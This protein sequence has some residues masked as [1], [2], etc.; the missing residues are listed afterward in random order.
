[1]KNLTSKQLRTI[2][3]SVKRLFG[4]SSFTSP[5][6]DKNQSPKEFLT[7]QLNLPDHRT[8]SLTDSGLE[9]MRKI[10]ATLDEANIFDGKVNYAD[11]WLACRQII[12]NF[13][14]RLEMPENSAE[15]VD[16]I[17]KNLS[18]KIKVFTFVVPLFGVEM[19]GIDEIPL[20]T[21]RVIKPS[22]DFFDSF[23][24]KHDHVDTK[25][26]F[27][28]SNYCL[29]LIGS[30]DGTL[31]VA[32]EKF[33]INAELSVG[34]LSVCAASMY[35]H[36]ASGF[37]IGTIMS[38]EQAYGRAIWISWDN[39][40]MAATMHYKFVSTQNFPVDT[41]LIQQLATSDV[42]KKAFS[43]IESSQRTPL[44]DAIARS[45]Y[46]FS[47]AQREK[48]QAMKL[49]KFWSCVEVFFSAENQDITRS[50]SVGLACVLV[51]G[52]YKFVAEQDYETLKKRIANLYK[53]RSRAVHRA[54]HQHVSYTDTA[55][56][57]KL[58]AQMILNMISFAE[59]GRKDVKEIKKATDQI[60]K[61]I[62]VDQQR[63]ELR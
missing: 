58:V 14:S 21:M 9:H 7:R 29:W 13:L 46:W 37:R 33:R 25:T 12:E 3:F 26:L 40:S 38:P 32:L 27:E 57:S 18:A 48:F 28:T 45:I 30:A 20:G 8:I 15:F 52:G 5:C 42:L 31:D 51:F 2:E 16:L 49:V 59:Q 4:D 23:G 55:D 17:R 22:M 24:I 10:V 63:S 19:D 54:S 41:H 34:I 60:D 11:V 35:E 61:R 1:M 56:L 6:V 53:L 39:A 62:T 43:I 47:D 44:E 50:V 36:G